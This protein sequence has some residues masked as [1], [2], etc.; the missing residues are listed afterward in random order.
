MTDTLFYIDSSQIR[1]S[2]GDPNDGQFYLDN[3]NPRHVQGPKN[4]G[5]Y[6]LEGD[7][8]LSDNGDTGF[9]LMADNK[10]F[11]PSQHLPWLD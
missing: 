10:I 8:F 9:R 6:W 11:G 5:K 3:A 7:Q 2:N 4:S 1:S